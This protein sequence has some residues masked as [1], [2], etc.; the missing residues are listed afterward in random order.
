VIRL[1]DG[2]AESA[3]RMQAAVDDLHPYT[4]ELFGPTRAS[5]DF[6][7]V[8]SREGM[9][10]PWDATIGDVFAEARLQIPEVAF[11]LSGG[12]EGRH[13][14]EFGHLLAELQYMQRTY[15]GLRW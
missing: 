2:T 4:E 1:G 8:P 13:G 9:R 5:V 14:E 7:V 15:P 6:A 11:A 10:A 12:R 3:R